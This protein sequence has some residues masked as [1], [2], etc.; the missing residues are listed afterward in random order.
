MGVG[1]T[2]A[3][4]LFVPLYL[5]AAISAPVPQDLEMRVILTHPVPFKLLCKLLQEYVHSFV[6]LEQGVGDR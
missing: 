4:S 1:V 2:V 5:E 3:T 6:P